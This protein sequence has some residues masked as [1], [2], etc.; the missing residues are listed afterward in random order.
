MLTAAARWQ[1]SAQGSESVF[2]KLFGL[3]ERAAPSPS[4]EEI[5]RGYS[6]YVERTGLGI[7]ICDERELPFP[8]KTILN[9]MIVAQSMRGQSEEMQEVMVSMTL[10]LA[11]FQPNIG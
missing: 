5:V 7:E 10:L 3:K 2:R 9:A 11:Q 8:K 1:Q 4:V 6:A